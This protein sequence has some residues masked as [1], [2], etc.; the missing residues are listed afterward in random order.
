MQVNDSISRLA[1]DI[2][3]RQ[4]EALNSWVMAWQ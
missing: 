2:Y 3:A 1:D 4:F